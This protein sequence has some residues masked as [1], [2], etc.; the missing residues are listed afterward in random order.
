MIPENASCI[1][2]VIFAQS[3]RAAI[4]ILTKE[5]VL[6]WIG[7][8]LSKRAPVSMRKALNGIV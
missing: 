1:P 3:S 6:R 7:L 2:R 4:F 5:T 8:S